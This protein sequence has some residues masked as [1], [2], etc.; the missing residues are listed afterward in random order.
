MPV[1]PAPVTP[2]FVGST[3]LPAI[4][5]DSGKYILDYKWRW[6]F[7]LKGDY[8]TLAAQVNAGIW[9]RGAINLDYPGWIVS[10]AELASEK[11]D[12]ATLVVHYESTGGQL[13][14]DEWDVDPEDLQ[15]HIER[16]PLFAALSTNDIALV[17]QAFTALTA[18]GQ[19]TAINQMQGIQNKDL[20][21]L[22]YNKLRQGLET[23]Y[24]AMARYTWTTYYLAGTLPNLAQGGV[25]QTPGGP[26][27]AVLPLGFAWL[28]LADK[29]GQANYGPLG[30]VEK[31]TRQWIGAPNGFW[32]PD[33]YPP[34]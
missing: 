14:P 17:Q 15:P 10:T 5:P 3:P 16:N 23:Y 7:K 12:S 26:A 30:A 27:G 9:S 2:I 33:I 18:S 25:T 34:G 24:L 29:A 28:R 11:P 21:T 1:T 8:P 13:N 22:L 4:Q 19:A 6:D 31:L 32:D 20:A